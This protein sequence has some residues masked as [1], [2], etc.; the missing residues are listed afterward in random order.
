MNK[1]VFLGGTCNGST[2]RNRLMSYLDKYDV[3]YFNPV[4]DNWNDDAR[5]NELMERKECD[6]LLYTITPKMTGVYAIAEAV[7]DSNKCPDKTVFIILRTDDDEIFTDTQWKS[8][9]AVAAMI[10]KN[11]AKVFN[12]LKSA[13]IW[14]GD[15]G[16]EK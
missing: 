4:V 6:V 3:D 15:M 11:G 8:L 1:K 2:W 10:E 5:E 9:V 12:D 14:I 16:K 7:D 13:A